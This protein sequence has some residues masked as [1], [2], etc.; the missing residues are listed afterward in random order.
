MVLLCFPESRQIT[1]GSQ[2][3]PSFDCHTAGRSESAAALQR[4]CAQPYKCLGVRR[5]RECSGCGV[6]HVPQCGPNFPQLEKKTGNAAR[7]RVGVLFTRIGVSLPQRSIP[8]GAAGHGW[9]LGSPHAWNE[10]HATD[11]TNLSGGRSPEC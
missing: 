4:Q 11:A 2:Q 7:P 6:S 9:Y 5:V 3:A 10:S 8:L 1:F